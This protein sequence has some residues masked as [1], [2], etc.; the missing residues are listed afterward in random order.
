MHAER[1]GHDHPWIDVSAAIHADMV[2]WPGDP[3]VQVTQLS[4]IAAGQ[5]YNLSWISMGAHSGTHIDAPLHLL[6]GAP[7]MDE[8]P[9]GALIGPAQV[10]EVTSERWVEPEDL[11]PFTIGPGDRI[12]LKTTNSQRCWKSSDFIEDYV[13]LS[14]AAAHYFV[15]RGVASV[16]IDYLS[17]GEYGPAGEDTHKTL[18]HAGIWIIEGLDL[19]AAAPGW[20]D[21]VCLPLKL[22]GAEGAPARV[23]LRR[24]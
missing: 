3:Q 17:I 7:S 18:M 22:T 1:T 24:R 14:P 2:R 10:I 9:F 20:Y 23:V 19:S 4:S 5:S 16:G 11:R 13:S 21:M 12:L 6:A 8:V 15:D